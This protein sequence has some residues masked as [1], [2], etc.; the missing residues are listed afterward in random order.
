[1][2]DAIGRALPVPHLSIRLDLADSSAS[3][4]GSLPARPGVFIL[5][6]EAGAALA[7]MTTANLR[8]A[9]VSKLQPASERASSRRIDYRKVTRRLCACTVGS[10]FEADWAYLQLARSCLPSTYRSL[11][12]RWQAWFVTCDPGATFPQFAKTNRPVYQ[13]PQRG[14]ID[15]GPMP[16]KHAA[17]RYIEMLEDAFDL[18]RYHHILVQAPRGAACA[19]KEMGRCPAP[20]D[21]SVSMDHYHQQVW[22]AIEFAVAPIADWRAGVETKMRLAAES[23]E[24]EA[25]QRWREVLSRTSLALKPEFAHVDRL[26]QFR[27]LG[28]MASEREGWA[29]LFLIAGGWIAPLL[30]LPLGSSDATLN[31]ALTAAMNSTCRADFSDRGIENIGLVCSH[32]FRSRA[33]KRSGVFLRLGDH[34]NSSAVRQ[35]LARLQGDVAPDGSATDTFIERDVENAPRCVE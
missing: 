25:A 11:L 22:D 4:F 1:V 7:L 30:D 29:R 21:G 10:A 16:D 23:M 34:P 6:D 20:C 33:T 31:Q 24:F 15:I 27:F 28:V 2:I 26:E 12:D 17:A 18:C 14:A 3:D 35:A 9:A 32:L 13:S 8:R 19:Y 5:E